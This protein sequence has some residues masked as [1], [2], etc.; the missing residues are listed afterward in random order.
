MATISVCMIVKNEEKVLARCLDSLAGLWEE[1]IIVDTGST[2]ATKEIAKKYTKNVYDFTWTENFSDARN[3]SFSKACCDYI[4]SADADE[5]L[6][7]E[8]R[9]KFLVLKNVLDS[10]SEIEIVQMYYGNQLSQNSIYNF[11]K[12]YR[13]KLYKRVRK[14]IWQEPIHEAVRLEP[15]V[16]DS[17]IVIWHKPHGQHGKRDLEYFEKMIAQGEMLSKR[18]QDIYLRELYFVGTEHNLKKGHDY[19]TQ[20]VAQ[21]SPDSDTFQKAVAILC[22]EARI[23]KKENDLLKFSL[24]GVASQGSSELCMELGHYFYEKEEW[25]EAV[26]WYY[27]AA[28]EVPCQM[29]LKAAT[30]GPLKQ[31]ISCYERLQMPKIA[32]EYKKKLK[33]LEQEN[34]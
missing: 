13:P 1:L 34:E 6:D 30:S 11:D 18:I 16:F 3:F 12:E 32:E 21:E 25:E 33:M 10:E 26:I 20:L 24:K 2:D 29:S 14:F 7:E 8:N 5:V 15:V 17:D 22:K 28:Y 19:L 27:N 23:L 4:Y 31:I 9:E